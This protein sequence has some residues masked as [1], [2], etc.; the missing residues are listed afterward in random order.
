MPDDGPIKEHMA[1]RRQ[2]VAR[3]GVT[4]VI[5][6][7]LFA[8]LVLRLGFLQI[9]DYSHY[10]TRSNNNRT[11]VTAVP[12][13]RGLI[14]D[15]NGVL[16]AENLPSY[17]LLVTPER[18]KDMQDALTQLGQVITLH[19]KD[20]QRF[21]K[22]VHAQPGFHS[23]VLRGNLSKQELARFEVNRYRFPGMEIQ[24]GL[25]RHYPLGKIGAH[26]IGYVGSISTRDLFDLNAKRY[27]GST[28]I[29]KTGVEKTYESILHGY[30]GFRIDETN[31][32][33]RALRELRVKPPTPGR[34][35]HLTIDAQLEATAYQAL[36]DQVGAVV[37][38]DPRNGDV[39]AMV[40][41]PS[42]DPNLFVGG[43]SSKQYHQL[44]SREHQPLFDRAIQGQYPP[45]STIKPVMAL[46]ALQTGSIKPNKKLWCPAYITLPH[47]SR[48]W[49]G[50]NR[51]GMGWVDLTEAIYRSSDIYFYQLGIKLGIDNMARFGKM[52]GLGHKTGID[53]P[54]EASGLMPSRAWKHG[55]RHRRWYPGE[56]LNTVI[57][58]G[59]VSATP[60]Q[61][62]QMAALIGEHGQGYEPHVLQ[63]AINP[64][65]GKRQPYVPQPVKPI[66]LDKEKYWDL[67]VHAMQEVITNTR[68]TAHRYIG[69]DLDYTI[70][71]K[72]GSAQVA[73][74]AQNQ[75]A[76]DLDELKWLQ[77]EHALFIAFVPAK[78]PRI[79][80]A[81]LVAHGGGGSSTASPIVR[82]I[83]D[84]YLGRADSAPADSEQLAK[85]G[86]SPQPPKHKP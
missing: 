50:W 29:G 78:H 25:T 84:A 30:P 67:V 43:I 40:S 74:I 38:L 5:M 82:K 77:R 72:S 13:V 62:A 2:F 1:E 17:R 68:G 76:P 65:D 12:P 53:L 3:L 80:V 55:A 73:S 64:A 31:A 23:I 59:Y 79:A 4:G 14:Y 61:L 21:L 16:L 51:Y 48:H 69:Q 49:R 83:T 18:V 63:A 28:Q 32:Q 47:G 86:A 22:K 24:A 36:G 9:L 42:F 57:G 46:A 70:A 6:A 66:H 11:R 10:T 75:A 15:R 27:R 35:L 20:K 19:A 52:F 71:G 33:G 45:G 34:N 81:V 85:M 26:I 7:V 41:K 39:L 8:A 44:L 37:A 54:H 58:Q 60:L 56:T